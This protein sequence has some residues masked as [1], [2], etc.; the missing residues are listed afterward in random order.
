MEYQTEFNGVP[1]G[2]SFATLH[3][4]LGL[5]T[6]KRGPKKWPNVPQLA[7]L[8]LH[9]NTLLKWLIDYVKIPTC[10]TKD[11]FT[12]LVHLIESTQGLSEW[13]REFSRQEP[14]PG[15]IIFEP[16]LQN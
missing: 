12:H 1:D 6:L 13:N 2:V 4:S 8:W 10:K 14:S 15:C 11:Y 9:C 16:H 3:S 5:H 7:D